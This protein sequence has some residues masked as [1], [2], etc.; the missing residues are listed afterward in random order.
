M[1]QYWD[2]RFLRHLQNKSINTIFEIGS[3]Y[4]DESIELGKNF[5]NSVIYSFE[6][7]P[8]TVE[9][10]QNKLKNYKNIKFFNYGVG[11]KNEEL[12]FFSFVKDNDGASSFFKRIDYDQTQKQT[13]IIKIRKLI[14]IVKENNIDSIDLLCMDVQGYELNILKGA[15][16]FLKK[17]KYIIIEQPKQIINTNYLPQGVHSKYIGAPSYDEIYNFMNENGF[18]LLEKIEENLIEDNVMYKNSSFN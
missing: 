6:C 7:N 12:P 3:R 15:E 11:D 9:I 14:D 16:E 18:E 13:G 17:I 1:T 8:L 10:C 5:K 2:I 4:G